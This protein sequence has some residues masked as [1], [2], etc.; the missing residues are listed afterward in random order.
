MIKLKYPNQAIENIMTRRS[1]RSFTDQPVARED[2]ELLARA[3]CFAPSANNSQVWQFTVVADREKI[4]ELAAAVAGALGRGSDYNFYNPSAFIISSAPRIYRLGREDCACAL[5]NI[6]L[7]AHSLGIGSV[8]INQL[9]LT[10]DHDSV[11]PVLDKLGV[12]ADHVVYG[13]AA[14]GY[15]ESG[16]SGGDAEKNLSVI[17]FA[18]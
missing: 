8:W 2:L 18:D 6:F 12:P 5:Q 14:L 16:N 11:R 4:A 15:P 3:A 1:V 13:C 10:C 17:H 7:A 9:S